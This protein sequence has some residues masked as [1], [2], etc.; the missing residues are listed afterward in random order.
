M[1]EDSIIVVG[2]V[3]C[4]FISTGCI[5]VMVYVVMSLELN[6]T[7]LPKYTPAAE[8]TTPTTLTHSLVVSLSA[9]DVQAVGEGELE[10]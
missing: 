10:L 2:F 4:A 7:L 8:L 6:Q 5:Q 1:L 3:F 9:S